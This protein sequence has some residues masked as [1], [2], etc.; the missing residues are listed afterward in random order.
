MAGSSCEGGGRSLHLLLLIVVVGVVVVVLWILGD[1]VP[2]SQE[3]VCAVLA[4]G[5]EEERRGGVNLR[6]G[7][8][9]R[10]R[11]PTCTFCY[12]SASP[13]SWR[14]VLFVSVW[15]ILYKSRSR[16]DNT[17]GIIDHF[18]CRGKE[19]SVVDQAHCYI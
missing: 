16:T 14:A 4:G 18:Q 19:D 12:W 15:D 8:S 3:C 9:S 10:C 1:N 5:L 7:R 11:A 13:E 2:Q 6:P 17:F